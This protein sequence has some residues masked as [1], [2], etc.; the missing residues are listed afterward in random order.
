M[1]EKLESIRASALERLNRAN[2]LKA[3]EELRL[4]L[5]GKKSELMGIL[6]S[7]GALSP[8]ERPAVGKMV[9]ETSAFIEEKL[10][11]A[12]QALILSAQNARLM[13]E[14]VDVTI[15]GKRRALGSRHPMQ[16]AL[17]E[18]TSVFL[19]MG[20]EI[21]E[22]P[23]IE[24]DYYNFEALNIPANHPAKDEQDTFYVEGGFVLRTQTSSVQIRT[25][26]RKRPPI[27][28][29]APGAVYRSDQVDATHSPSF[30]QLEALVVDHGITMGDLKGSLSAFIRQLF[31]SSTQVRFRPHH[32]PFTE[33]SAEMDASCFFCNGKGC[34]ICKGSGWIEILGCGMVHPK[35]LQ[36]AGID[37]DEYTGFAFGVGVERIAMLR[38]DI[39]DM[40]LLFENDIR[41]LNQF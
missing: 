37:P 31:G 29:I 28:I 30:H 11:Q 22:G 40:R 17:D 2:D 39:S 23:D 38:F 4:S 33:P 41:F 13:S 9:N 25:M 19:G 32:F 18:V 27:K 15:P 8:E 7:L 1:K 3:I 35:V 14:A 16:L 6:K 36:L 21:A 20:Y 5:I 10:S 26:E 24:T 12:K 34:R